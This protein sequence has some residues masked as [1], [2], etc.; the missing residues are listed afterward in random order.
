MLS[1]VCLYPAKEQQGN[2]FLKTIN[3]EQ[4]SLFIPV[5]VFE[6]GDKLCSEAKLSCVGPTTSNSSLVLLLVS[7]L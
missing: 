1:I 2:P 6:A 3:F 5:E 7:V 4:E